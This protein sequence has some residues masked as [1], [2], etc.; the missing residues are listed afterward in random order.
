MLYIIDQSVADHFTQG[1]A[2]ADDITGIDYLTMG[3]AE[4]NHRVAGY[5]T[6]LQSLAGDHLAPPRARQVLTR[7]A[8]RAGQEGRLWESLNV[9]GSVVAG[10]GLGT[11]PTST[12]TATQ[13]VIQF[14]LRWFN[15]SGKVQPTILLGE[16]LSDVG[17]LDLIAKTAMAA[18]KL[19][20]MPLSHD[21]RSGGG[22][23]TV[24]T[25]GSIIATNR[26]CIC[27]VDSD[28]ACPTAALG[29][30]A[31]S[32]QAFKDPGQ[33]PV[34]EILE[35]GGRELE[36]SLPD[37]FYQAVYGAHTPQS[38][39]TD[40][41]AHFTA[42]GDHEA[43]KHIDIGRGLV[44]RQMYTYTLGSPERIF[45]DARVASISTALGHPP[46]HF[47]CVAT[48]TCATAGTGPCTCVVVQ[49]NLQNILERF[50]EVHAVDPGHKLAGLLSQWERSEWLRLGLAIASWCCAEP[51]LRI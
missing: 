49:G 46:N 12:S 32:L 51:R 19:Q 21:R 31:L 7:A 27:V 4:G 11:G 2:T 37:R 13:R 47:A 17:V 35:T 16:N 8:A 28:R 26:Q 30:T 15:A 39:M 24:Q 14:P 5:R 23:S 22:S 6:V 33:Y 10:A 41:L 9:Y 20:Y 42:S 29:A 25:L 18:R 44:L 36:N 50:V 1:R 38:A 3:I 40:V 34:V 45:W 48:S 43:R